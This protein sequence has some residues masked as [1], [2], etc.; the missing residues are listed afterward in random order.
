MVGGGGGG[1][2]KTRKRCFSPFIRKIHYE[3]SAITN[4]ISFIFRIGILIVSLQLKEFER[5][6]WTCIGTR[7][8][9]RGVGIVRFPP[10]FE[11]RSI[12]IT[13]LNYS[14]YRRIKLR[15]KIDFPGFDPLSFPNVFPLFFLPAV[16]PSPVHALPIAR[17]I[18]FS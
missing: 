8:N 13:S 18:Q 14:N 5:R 15:V 6:R 3:G 9:N 16:D 10:L 1:W 2:I 11:S 12:L 17:L 4:D 7:N